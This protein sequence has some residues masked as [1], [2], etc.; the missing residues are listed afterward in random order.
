[1]A[2]FQ[3]AK[4]TTATFIQNNVVAQF[5]VIGIGLILIFIIVKKLYGSIAN[6][7]DWTTGSTVDVD[8]G[9]IPNGWTPKQ[10]ALRL[11]EELSGIFTDEKAVE[12]LCT[13]ANALNDDQIR[14]LHNY[15]NK[16]IY[17][18]YKT[19]YSNNG[20]VLYD[21]LNFTDL[22]IF[23]GTPQRD[24]LRLRLEELGLTFYN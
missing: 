5:L 6:L 3:K 23:S 8:K 7:F 16:N 19:F 15:W 12:N 18:K 14:S 22:S 13:E 10:L 17:K 20:Y 11:Y 4:N 2:L 21:A 9:N 24:Q 1:M